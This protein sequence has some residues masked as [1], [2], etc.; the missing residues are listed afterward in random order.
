MERVDNEES[1]EENTEENTEENNETELR[2]YGELVFEQFV[3]CIIMQDNVRYSIFY[4]ISRLNKTFYALTFNILRKYRSLY[5]KHAPGVASRYARRLIS[6]PIEYTDTCT[7]I[8]PIPNLMNNPLG[9]AFLDSDPPIFGDDFLSR[10]VPALVNVCVLLRRKVG[11]YYTISFGETVIS[12]GCVK[13]TDIIELPPYEQK[14]IDAM[15]DR[16]A[17]E[18][19]DPM[20][21]P[22]NSAG[23]PG[24]FFVDLNLDIRDNPLL[25]SLNTISP[26]RLYMAVNYLAYSGDVDGREVIS[27]YHDVGH[28]LH[29]FSHIIAQFNTV[30][31]DRVDISKLSVHCGEVNSYVKKFSIVQTIEKIEA[32]IAAADA[33]EYAGMMTADDLLSADPYKADANLDMSPLPLLV[34]YIDEPVQDV[35]TSNYKSEYNQEYDSEYNPDYNY[36]YA[37]SDDY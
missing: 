10:K 25:L 6:H 22:M 30:S 36:D 2:S 27:I 17:L 1:S 18:Q 24:R 33:A 5:Y 23:P 8:I 12:M 32:K 19:G 34:D 21:D 7:R 26:R 13:I 4:Q 37:S 20:L 29:G 11:F 31:V 14:D 15:R 35:V 9:L 16:L 3:M 28:I